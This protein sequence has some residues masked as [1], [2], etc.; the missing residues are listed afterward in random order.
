[1]STLQRLMCIQLTPTSTDHASKF[2]FN[3]MQDRHMAVYTLQPLLTGAAA[4]PHSAG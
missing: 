3:L 4:S 1:M 2:Y